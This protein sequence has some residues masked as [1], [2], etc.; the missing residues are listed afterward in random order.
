M[1]SLKWFKDRIGKTIYRDTNNC[2][3]DTCKNVLINGIFIEDMQVAQYLFDIQNDM[4]Y[5]GIVL[6]Y[7]DKQKPH[8]TV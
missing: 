1:K 8:I 3:C 7:R 5:E 6:N 4:K 2:P